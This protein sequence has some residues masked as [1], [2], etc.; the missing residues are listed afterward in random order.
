MFSVWCVPLFDPNHQS[1]QLHPLIPHVPNSFV[2]SLSKDSYK[3]YRQI[4]IL[5]LQLQTYVNEMLNGVE[6]RNFP[7]TIK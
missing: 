4:Q 3:R 5:N 1:G 2:L 7:P 6:G